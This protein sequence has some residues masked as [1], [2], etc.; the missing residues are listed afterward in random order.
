M[1]HDSY[2]RNARMRNLCTEVVYWFKYV[3]IYNSRYIFW[4]L[5]LKETPTGHKI[6]RF[7]EEFQ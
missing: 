1:K 5:S 7:I 4:F 3:Y 2:T 6:I